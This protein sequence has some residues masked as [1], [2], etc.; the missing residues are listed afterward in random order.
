MKIFVRIFCVLLLLGIFGFGFYYFGTTVPVRLD[1]ANYPDVIHLG[2][3]VDVGSIS[4]DLVT[5]LDRR[6]SVRGFHVE[7]RSND[8][9]VSY[10]CFRSVVPVTTL[11]P[12]SYD[13]S[14]AG[15]LYAG[16]PMDL[17]KL[18]V[19][20]VYSDGFTSPVKVTSAPE[21]NLP[22]AE[23]VQMTIETVVGEAVWDAKLMVPDRIEAYYSSDVEIGDP[24]DKDKMSVVLYYPDN[25]EL[26][27]ETFEV[28]GAPEYLS[29]DTIV[30]V[31]CDYGSTE[32][33]L[34]PANQQRLS[35]VYNGKVYAGDTL[36][37]SC[38][39]LTMIGTD[40]VEHQIDDLWFD[41]IGYI[42][43]NT[44]V[45]VHS[46]YGSGECYVE[47][48][49]VKECTADISGELVEGAPIEIRAIRLRY[50][51]DTVRTLSQ[52]D[53]VL[54]NLGNTYRSGD[55]DAW[56]DYHGMHFSFPLLVIPS[57]VAS[58]RNSDPNVSGQLFTTYSLTEAQ[59]DTIAI[60]CQRAAGDDIM[61]AA[62]EVSLLANR[63]ELYG[64]ADATDGAY[65]VKYMKEDGYWG[66]DVN[67]YIRTHEA[68]QTVRFVVRDA[69]INGHRVF[70]AY[71]DDRTDIYSVA[72]TSTGG[73]FEQYRSEIVKMDGSIYWFYSFVSDAK[74]VAYGYTD[75]AYQRVTGSAP[76][77]AHVDLGLTDAPGVQNEITIDG[78]FVE[79]DVSE[80]E[81]GTDYGD[82]GIIIF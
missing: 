41:D 65:I 58:I 14:Y 60:L 6:T 38:V 81:S 61:L 62:A 25:M 68:D 70:P 80:P 67:D 78:G 47:V 66:S 50:E 12:V 82:D 4:V 64:N 36:D 33:M 7:Q 79:P 45:G 37:P 10:D 55:F 28:E 72:K 27:V 56:F 69:L 35:A 16:K 53:I 26:N 31:I 34:K 32:L 63:F 19:T 30:R 21:E 18:S 49:P 57:N 17:S 22:F 40:G 1:V 48:I 51:D 59:I 75:L 54:S 3:N 44:R 73:T 46:N 52:D 39:V 74:N 76:P 8:I 11:A 71:V 20:A 5:L 9:V 24:F 23:S 2:E 43:A 29:E 13:V 77:Y 42:K 15:T